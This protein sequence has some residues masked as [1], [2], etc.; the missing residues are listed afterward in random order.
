MKKNLLLIILLPLVILQSCTTRKEMLY[1][2]DVDKYANTNLNY[3]S[4]KIQTND[5][6]KIEVGDL[7]PVVAAPFNISS[8]SASAQ[9]SVEMM[10]LSGYLVTPKGFVMMPILNEIKVGGLTPT[11]AEVVI[12]NRLINEGYLVNPTVQVRVLNNKFTILGEV[13]APG[14]IPF[15]EESI[16]VLDAIGLAK[17]L[18]YSAIR[19]DIQLIREQDG[20]RLV[21]HI[22]LTTAH[23]MSNPN[24]RIRQN[25]VIVVTPNKLKANSGGLIKDPLQVL[26]I[27]ASLLAI[28]LLIA[29]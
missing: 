19:K 26:G 22:D 5:I 10:K 1:L 6:L 17:D 29:K 12:K 27:A 28:I 3:V 24:F 16:S 15:T 18:T 11:E 25:D 2:Q 23:W 20:K 4:T 13:N 8:G 9:S 7:N 21:Y 14:V